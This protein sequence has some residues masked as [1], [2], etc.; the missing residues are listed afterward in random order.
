[1]NRN[2]RRRIGRRVNENSSVI[3]DFVRFGNLAVAAATSFLTDSGTRATR[4]SSADDSFK[5]T[6]CILK[7]VKAHLANKR[8]LL[9]YY[10]MRQRQDY[11]IS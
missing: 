1:V 2:R 11:M 7:M 9:K 5:T 4:N 8:F 3:D 6:I 10:K